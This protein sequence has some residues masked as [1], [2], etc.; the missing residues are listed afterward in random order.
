[1]Q[2]VRTV[3]GRI[4][5]IS[6]V[7]AILD[8]ILHALLAPTYN[9][10]YPPSYSV[11]SG[12]FKPAAGIALLII[13]VLLG[14]VFFIQENLPGRK[15]LKG[16]RFGVSFGGLWLIGVIGMSIFLGFPLRHELLGGACDCAALTILGVLLGVFTATDSPRGN[17]SPRRVVPAIIVIAFFFVIGQYLASTLM[18][19]T[20]Y[21]NIS[22]LATFIW[23]A[24]L[25]LWT[26]VTYWLLQQGTV[27]ENS[28]IER[29]PLWWSHRRDRLDFV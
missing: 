6:M 13:F 1:M 21:F 24:V 4:L 15:V 11:R 22:G 8:V 26:G 20:P 25:G 9:Y 16:T 3:L 29:S 5:S 17:A 27:K 7:S 19:G 14:V 23:T 10:D 18:S 12:L 2:R 28:P